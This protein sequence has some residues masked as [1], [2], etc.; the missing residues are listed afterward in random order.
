[1]QKAEGWLVREP[2]DIKIINV[3]YRNVALSSDA[4]LLF[5]KQQERIS[6]LRKK[7][8]FEQ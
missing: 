6:L 2:F 8:K 1:M 7:N 5:R 4:Y 3:K